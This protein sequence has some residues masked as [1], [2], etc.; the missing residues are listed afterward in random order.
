MSLAAMLVILA[1][2]ALVVGWAV[3][4]YRDKPTRH[5]NSADYRHQHTENPD[6]LP[7]SGGR[8]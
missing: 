5:R 2:V 1:V 8:T 7:G 3:L 6:Y 4:T